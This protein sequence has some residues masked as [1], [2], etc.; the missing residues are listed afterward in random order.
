M[1]ACQVNKTHVSLGAKYKLKLF[2]TKMQNSE[3]FKH[4]KYI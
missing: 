2:V 3:I 1:V 4:Q